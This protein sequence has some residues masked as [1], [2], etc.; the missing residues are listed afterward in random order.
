MSLVDDHS[1]SQEPTNR[2]VVIGNILNP[3]TGKYSTDNPKKEN[4]MKI[5]TPCDWSKLHM[6]E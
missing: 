5:V 3:F 1:S 4:N 2:G 6:T